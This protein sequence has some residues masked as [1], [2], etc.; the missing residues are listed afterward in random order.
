M[1]KIPIKYCLFFLISFI[2]LKCYE[3]NAQDISLKIHV[4]G[5][6][7]TKIQLLPLSGSDAYNPISE[8]NG[9]K[10]SETITI[11]INKERLPGEFV[12]LF[13]YKDKPNATPVSAEKFLIMYKQNIELWINPLHHN[14]ADSTYFQK[15]EKENNAYNIVNNEL[16]AKKEK[17]G[18]LHSFL[19]NYDDTESSFYKQ[20]NDEY[21]KRRNDFNNWLKKQVEQY[22]ELFMSSLLLFEYVPY[23]SFKG[24]EAE[25]LKNIIDNYFE[26]INFNDSQLVKTS[27]FS[28]WMNNY[29]NLYG[30]MVRNASQ[31]DSLFAAA[32][33]NAIEKAKK[34]HPL[35]YGWMV[36]YFYKGYE[37]NGIDAG[38]K[39]LEPYINDPNC[40]TTKQQEINKRLK[41]IATLVAG[42]K[43]PNIIMKDINGNDFELHK[44]KIEQPYILLLFW[45]A[46]CNH[47]EE[48]VKKLY[49]WS[50]KDDIKKK[51]IILAFS[52]DENQDEIAEYNKKVK[53]LVGWQHLHAKE[54]VNSKAANDYGILSSPVMFLIES[55]NFFIK[56]APASI[57]QIEKEISN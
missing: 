50:L 32:G 39:I 26:G 41:A 54:G 56:G 40:L 21:E 36:D 52:M 19:M 31:R 55:K 14:N 51:I 7:E 34:G 42:A 1:K 13:E 18:V 29:V 48:T 45:S 28:N 3:L 15:D 12:L 27:N 37:A 4:R 5:V 33:I 44:W 57:E 11:T 6:Y 9:I 25:R 23:I 22:K 46:G 8:K 30:S 49:P 20:G 2:L 10:N 24:N 17:L 53:D 38:M 43:A 35:V 16:N 47:C